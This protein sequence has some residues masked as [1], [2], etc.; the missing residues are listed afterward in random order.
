MTLDIF[1]PL[2][3]GDVV[4]LGNRVWRKQVL[5]MTTIKYGDRDLRFDR[6]YIDNVAAAFRAG[7]FDTVPFVLA[8]DDNSHTMAA[9]RAKGEVLGLEAADDGLYA[10]VRLSE[11]AEQLVRDNPRFG[12]SVRLKENYER[13]DGASFPV[14]CQH[15]LGT[16]DPKITGMKPWQQVEL[17]HT[18]GSAVID[19]S[20]LTYKEEGAVP[21]TKNTTPPAPQD[22]AP[23]AWFTAWLAAGA[24]GIPAAE[25]A[26]NGEDTDNTDGQADEDSVDQTNDQTDADADADA[27]ADI[28]DDEFMAQIEGLFDAQDVDEPAEVAA[29]HS[30]GDDVDLA[31]V[32]RDERLAAIELSNRQLQAQLDA[33][34]YASERAQLVRMSGLT[35]ADIDLARPLLEGA[36]RTVELSNGTAV[37]AGEIVRSLLKRFGETVRLLD[38]SGEIGVG[39][40]LAAADDAEQAEKDR[41]A[42]ADAFVSGIG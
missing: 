41:A 28:S 18:P 31:N 24:P 36:G 39:I 20:G 1:T 33:A 2:A 40:E 25:Q 23:P 42:K 6:A 15:V 12:V 5:P 35:P 29:S 8:G 3:G 34:N 16:W 38:L 22:D 21:D 27:D 9:E 30:G 26:P 37:D 17:S 4:E 32:A 13:P 10:T 11:V 14:A 19:L 7:A